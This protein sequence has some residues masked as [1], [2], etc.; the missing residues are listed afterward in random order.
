MRKI[1]SADAI[2]RARAKSA[3]EMRN[4]GK[5]SANVF[6]RFE[7]QCPICIVEIYPGESPNFRVFVFF[8]TNEDVEAA[9]RDGTCQQIIDFTYEEFERFGRGKRDEIDVIFEFDSEENV[10]KHYQGSYQARMS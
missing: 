2:A 5:V 9:K 1:P 3:E 8:K 6:L 4:V 10:I 7:K